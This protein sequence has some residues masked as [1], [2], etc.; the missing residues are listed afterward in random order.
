MDFKKPKKPSAW[1]I[2][3]NRGIYVE[4]EKKQPK[5]DSN[6][7]KSRLERIQKYN[8][9]VPKPIDDSYFQEKEPEKPQVISPETEMQRKIEKIMA[10]ITTIRSKMADPSN[11]LNRYYELQKTEKQF[12]KLVEDAKMET[13]EFPSEFKQKLEKQ[14]DNLRTIKNYRK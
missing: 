5:Q 11:Y 9:F 2:I 1:D 6:S 10:Q 3:E 13:M 4:P 12:V 7:V 14:I 8:K